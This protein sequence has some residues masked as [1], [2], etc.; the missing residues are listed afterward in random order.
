MP[1]GPVPLAPSGSRIRLF[2]VVKNATEITFFFLLCL[3]Y[4][5]L[6]SVYTLKLIYY[7][8]IFSMFSLHNI[9]SAFIPLFFLFLITRH[10]MVNADRVSYNIDIDLCAFFKVIRYMLS[11]LA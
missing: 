2:R 4:H 7:I 5:I 8:C 6:L 1:V 11:F 9:L 3:S 10:I